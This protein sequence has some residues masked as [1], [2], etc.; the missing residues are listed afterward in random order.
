MANRK[1]DEHLPNVL[2][3]ALMTRVAILRF[4]VEER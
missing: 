2:S 3:G 4:L 1:Q